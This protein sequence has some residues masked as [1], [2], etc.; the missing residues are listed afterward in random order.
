MSGS[1]TPFVLNSASALYL[2][3]SGTSAATALPRV[4]PGNSIDVRVYGASDV[5]VAFG[6]SSVVATATG[7]GRSVKFMGRQSEAF[8]PAGPVMPTHVAILQDTAAS[9]IQFLVGS[10]A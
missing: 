6:D 1:E 2:T 9:D 8:T 4:M 5:Y 10:G 3:S 7:T